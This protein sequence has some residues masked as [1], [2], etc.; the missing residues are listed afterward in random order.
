MAEQLTIDKV[1]L[2][3]WHILGPQTDFCCDIIAT[4][5]DTDLPEGERY[6][7]LFAAIPTLLEALEGVIAELEEMYRATADTKAAAQRRIED[8]PCLIAARAA[9]TL[10]TGKDA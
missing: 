10:A 6:A 4:I 8:A 7:H 5:H 1:D 9:I 3:R 2:S